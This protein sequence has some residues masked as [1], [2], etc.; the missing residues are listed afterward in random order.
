MSIVGPFGALYS[1]SQ[2][3][4]LGFPNCFGQIQF[5]WSR[6]GERNDYAGYYQMRPRPGGAILVKMRHYWPTYTNSPT[7]QNQRSTFRGGVQAWQALTLEQKA[8]YNNLKYPRYMS[9]FNR[10]MRKYMKE[11]L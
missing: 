8:V 5:G 3:N 11:N 4:K 7:Q 6:F 2:V 10:F 9:G 1:L